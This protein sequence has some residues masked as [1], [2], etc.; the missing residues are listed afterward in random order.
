MKGESWQVERLEAY[1][2]RVM[3]RPAGEPGGQM[4]QTT[5]A[6]L[7]RH[8]DCRVS[9]RSAS[10]IPAAGRGRQ[11]ATWKDLTR[12][13]RGLLELGLAH[14]LEVE[15][16]FRSGDPFQAGTEEPRPEYDPGLVPLVT[17]RRRAK[18]AELAGLRERE[19]EHARLLGLGKVSLRTLERWAARYYS[20][21][22]LGC[23]DDRWL[24]ECTG[25]RIPEPV[26]EAIYAVRPV[27]L[28]S[29]RI[30]MASREEKIHQY[31]REKY[32]DD[33]MIPSSETL[34]LVWR[35]L[36]GPGGPPPRGPP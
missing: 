30:S 33:V 23:A 7:M 9:S 18:V 10:R 26:R 28:H 19:P 8:R 32:G 2:G 29:S 4:R 16:G 25:H 15:T 24:R 12:Q 1:W 21:G 14:L 5:I 22:V 13:E 34:R 17:D 36:V 11:P 27:C 31:V 3:L 20:W 6:A 35:G